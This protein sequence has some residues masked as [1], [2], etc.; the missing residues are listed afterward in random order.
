M[1]AHEMRIPLPCDEALWSAPSAAQVARVQSSLQTNGVKPTMF[2]EGKAFTPVSKRVCVC[3]C[4][5]KWL[6]RFDVKKRPQKDLE[7]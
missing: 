7:W 1:V 3:V 4:K 6:I 2:L 5:V